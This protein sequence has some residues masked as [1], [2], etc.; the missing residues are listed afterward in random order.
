MSSFSNHSLSG[1]EWGG[2]RKKKGKFLKAAEK[3]KDSHI[4]FPAQ[5][6]IRE[7]LPSDSPFLL[8]GMWWDACVLYN[9]MK[10]RAAGACVR[11]RQ[12][13]HVNG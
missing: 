13:Q 9:A 2:G 4:I 10:D 11:Y 8:S 12:A 1:L 7:V 5:E 3:F 6:K